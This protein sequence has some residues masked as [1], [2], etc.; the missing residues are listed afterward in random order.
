ML[1][2]PP[3]G[4]QCRV[5]LD[6]LVLIPTDGDS[7]DLRFDPIA[8]RVRLDKRRIFGDAEHPF[9]GRPGHLGVRAIG[10]V[11]NGRRRRSSQLNL[12]LVAALEDPVLERY[13]VSPRVRLARLVDSLGID[14]KKRKLQL[15]SFERIAV[16]F[17]GC[18]GSVA[19]DFPINSI[20]VRRGESQD[21]SAGVIVASLLLH[22]N[23]RF[24]LRK[25]PFVDETTILSPYVTEDAIVLE[26][27]KR[28]GT[29]PLPLG[30]RC[31]AAFDL[32]PGH[33]LL[34]E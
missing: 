7:L 8:L 13:A 33:R 14:S 17:G 21:D 16:E 23:Y 34:R 20:A 26:L 31:R 19:P 25:R 27:F 10:G 32:V 12:F 30:C 15:R 28:I 22:R 1:P 2:P 11:V 24:G 3:G 9:I 29:V 6:V 5:D 18:G 4:R